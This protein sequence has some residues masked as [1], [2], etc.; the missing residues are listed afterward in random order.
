MLV[1]VLIVD[2]EDVIR[3]ALTEYLSVCGYQVDSAGALS[4]AEELLGRGEYAILITDLS[5]QGR[6]GSEGLHL[7]GLGR[8]RHPRMGTI[9]LT[10]Y[11]SS[12]AEA[13]ARELG[14]EAFLHKPAPLGE[15][16][17]VVS[18][19]LRGPERVA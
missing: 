4:Q 12:E 5:L 3:F 18:R 2:D 17:Q 14:V 7:A 11:G 6:G 8:R 15:I 19:I 9:I 16:A 1:R 10:A 13:A